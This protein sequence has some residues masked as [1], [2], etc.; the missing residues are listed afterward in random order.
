MTFEV[1]KDLVC[2]FCDV[3][4]VFVLTFMFETIVKRVCVDVVIK[5]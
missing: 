5:C 3:A 2:Y 1:A 4:T